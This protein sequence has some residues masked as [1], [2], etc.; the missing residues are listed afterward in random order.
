MFAAN[1]EV[2]TRHGWKAW[3]DVTVRDQL[4]CS[5]KG[6]MRF[7]RPQELQR[8]SYW[9]ELLS[10]HSRRLSYLV[11]PGHELSVQL[12]T[13]VRGKVVWPEFRLVPASQLYARFARH[14]VGGIP[15]NGGHSPMTYTIP[16]APCDKSNPGGA[17]AEPALLWFSSWASFLAAYLADGSFTYKPERKEY[18]VE[19]GK[20]W[21]RNPE[22]AETMRQIL[23][24]LPFRFRYEQGRRFIISGKALAAY[25]R[26]FGKSRTKFIPRYILQADAADRF[27]FLDVITT[28]DCSDRSA[29]MRCY[30]SASKQ[31]RDDVTYLA[32]TLG[33]STALTGH[34]KDPTKVQF[35]VSIRNVLTADIAANN[36]RK[37]H[38]V[39]PYSGCVYAAAVAGGLLLTRLNGKAFWSGDGSADVPS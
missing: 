19:L 20:V 16:E 26:Q 18:R 11:T 21:A 31:L 14:R 4:G 17:A 25:L 2:F 3:P 9:G 15:F 6:E 28:M 35:G 10:G 33:F 22:E 1:T 30:A 5:I 23:E 24:Q 37:Q 38:C 32:T 34:E 13:H 8:R 39:V 27:Q 7:R 36:T 12:R 29:T